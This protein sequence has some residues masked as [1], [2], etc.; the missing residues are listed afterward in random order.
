[1][2]HLLVLNLL[3]RNGEHEAFLR[4]KLGCDNW[5]PLVWHGEGGSLADE[6]ER[7]LLN[8]DGASNGIAFS[9]LVPTVVLDDALH[10]V[11]NLE[12]LAN[13]RASERVHQ[14]YVVVGNGNVLVSICAFSISIGNLHFQISHHLFFSVASWELHL[15]HVPHAF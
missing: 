10:L 5:L 13:H 7:R 1:M 11:L 6:L 15:S 4:S 9:K 3:I 12:E 2:E 8:L 14:L